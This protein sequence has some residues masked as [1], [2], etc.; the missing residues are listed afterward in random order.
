MSLG[1]K[2]PCPPTLSMPLTVKLTSNCVD[3]YTNAGT[4]FIWVLCGVFGIPTFKREKIL[5]FHEHNLA[6]VGEG[7]GADKGELQSISALLSM[8]FPG[9]F[10]PH[11]KIVFHLPAPI[12]SLQK[13]GIFFIHQSARQQC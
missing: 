10:H 6:G 3:P 13:S 12:L 8:S 5:R 1:P 11:S 2:I 9:V 7:E 4:R